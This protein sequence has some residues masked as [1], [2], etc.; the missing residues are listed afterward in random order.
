M[1]A[2]LSAGVVPQPNRAIIEA[3]DRSGLFCALASARQRSAEAQAAIAAW[4]SWQ[5][6]W[7]V[8]AYL[9]AHHIPAHP[10]S[11]PET[12]VNEEHLWSRHAL[13]RVN[14]PAQG[15]LVVLQA[16]WRVMDCPNG[17]RPEL[18]PGPLFGAHT[19]AILREWIGMDGGEIDR[20][21]AEGVFS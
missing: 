11:A 20:L 15:E 10:T 21:E 18:R 5:D 16:P 2:D 3:A 6:P 1:R 19:R 17:G 4:T 12:E 13:A 14:H 9:A 8:A 7:S